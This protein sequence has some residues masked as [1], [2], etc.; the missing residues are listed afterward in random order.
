MRGI[1]T[2]GIRPAG[3]RDE[4]DSTAM[5]IRTLV[6][7]PGGGLADVGAPAGVAFELSGAGMRAGAG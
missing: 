1:Q 3:Q 5:L 2:V 4:P 6:A 7:L